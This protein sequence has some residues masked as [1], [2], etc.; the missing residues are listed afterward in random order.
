MKYLQFTDGTKIPQLGLGTWKSAPG[1]VYQAVIDAVNAGYR[2]I[3]CA[4]IYGNESEI[5][6]ALTHL[7]KSGSVKREDLFI[8][9]KLWNNAHQPDAAHL[10]LKKTLSDLQLDYLDLYLIHWPIS[11]KVDA[12]FPFTG[13]D[14]ISPEELPFTVTWKAMESMKKSG[15]ARHI[16][17]SNFSIPNLNKLI[18]SA[19]LMPEMNQVEMHPFLAQKELF[20][21]C[22]DHDILVTAYS[23]LGSSDRSSGMKADDEPSLLQNEV[24]QGIA[25][26]LDCSPAQVLLAWALQRGT[27]VIPKSTNKGRIAENF[28]AQ[29][30]SLSSDQMKK[31]EALDGTYRFVNGKFWT[32]QGSPYTLE[33]LWG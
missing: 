10:A 16:G 19:E 28:R 2:H 5:G 12:G 13:S 20:H 1:E 23:P 24:I 8:T 31:L 33:Y 21:F 25:G 17:V 18:R 26:D 27:A 3:D 6:E 14:F 22:S 32:P 29:D 15:L 30:I 11:I 4:A 7:L 9:S